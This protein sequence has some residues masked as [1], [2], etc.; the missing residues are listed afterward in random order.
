[1]A[2]SKVQISK[3]F[4]EMEIFEVFGMNPGFELVRFFF[5]IIM[6]PLFVLQ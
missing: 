5:T 1:M 2:N 3:V 4:K 6:V